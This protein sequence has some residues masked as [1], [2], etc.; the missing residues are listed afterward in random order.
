MTGATT[1][2]GL[3]RM[4]T[5][6]QL[7]LLALVA[8]AIALGVTVAMW[9]QT[10]N[11]TMLH[12]ALSGPDA[13]EVMD[14]LQR[15]GIAFKVDENSGAV[16]VETAQFHM[17]RLKLAAEG[18]PRGTGGAGYRFLEEERSF[19]T[20]D[21]VEKKRYHHAQEEELARSVTTLSSVKSARVHLAMPS[22]SVFLRDQR[23][24]SASVIVDLYPGRQLEAGQGEAV[25]YMVASAVPGLDPADV[26]VIDGRGRRLNA[27]DDDDRMGEATREFEHARKLEADYIKR[28]E[29]LLSPIVGEGG[30]KAQV[31]AELDFTRTE[32]ATERFTPN[33]EAIRS[34]KLFREGTSGEE[35]GGIPGAL[36]NQPPAD[37][38]APETA[39][40]D[41]AGETAE[42]ADAART[43]SESTRNYELDRTFEHVVTP[44]SVIRKLSVAVVVDNKKPAEGADGVRE[45]RSD[46]EIALITALVKEAIAYDEERGDRV[47]V[48]NAAFEV[49]EVVIEELPPE[50][51]WKQAWVLNLA[52]QAGGVLLI[53]LIAFGVLRPAM[54]N[55]VNRDLAEREMEQASVEQAR[56]AAPEA[57]LGETMNT[58]TGEMLSLENSTDQANIDAIRQLVADDPKRVA[59]VVKN[60]VEA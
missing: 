24:P 56:L 11:F 48:T 55:L 42:A 25:A 44:S 51:I 52:K 45:P 23:A 8:G 54:R 50:P 34:E 26:Q 5:P 37:A 57:Q 10:P 16:L 43:R 32:Q 35:F 38:Q 53:L 1:L 17:A 20:S 60:W 6:R 15:E 33:R 21:F 2:N 59:N 9:S 3:N 12:G 36:S 27:V 49:T 4:S 31:T 7:Y 29:R 46:E 39:Q 30:V 13:S 40:G 14:L 58:E 22:Q 47:N 19:G 18:L 41:A 28:I